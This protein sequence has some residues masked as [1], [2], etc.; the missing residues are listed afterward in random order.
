MQLPSLLYIYDPLCGWC[1]GFSPVLKKLY[2]S[3]QDK[4]H[5]EVYSGGMMLGDRA[6]SIND[7]APY[8]K[9]AYKTV[10]QRTGVVFGE[11][12]LKDMLEPGTAMLNSEKPCIALTVFK[13]YLPDRA[14]EFAH[15]LQDALYQD[16][17]DLTQDTIYPEL[18]VPLGIDPLEFVEKLNSTDFRRKTY[19][20]FKIVSEIGVTGFPTVLLLT[21]KQNYLL[22]RGYTDYEP[23]YQTITQIIP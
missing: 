9:T 1:Y 14:V 7:V 17:K 5:F 15:I 10:E 11:P 8:I 23:L 3:L 12:F 20:E 21:E 16:G 6:G 22:S 2:E 4:L 19:E 18:V 13:S